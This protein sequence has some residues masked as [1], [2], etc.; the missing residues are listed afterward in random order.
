MGE[1]TKLGRFLRKMRI[2]RGELLRDMSGKLGVAVSFLSSVENGKKSMPTEWAAKLVQ[3]YQL[4][5]LQKRGLDEAIAE[6]E[7]GIGVKFEGLSPEKRQLS[8]AFARKIQSLS[9]S[10]QKALQKVLF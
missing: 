2:D 9:A 7:K 5:D 4:S 3:I 1:L 8:V 10:D 6:S